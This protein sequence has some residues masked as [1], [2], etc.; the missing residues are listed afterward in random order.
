[1]DDLPAAP[2]AKSKSHKIV[3]WVLM[4]GLLV[5][6]IP[7]LGFMGYCTDRGWLDPAYQIGTYFLTACLIWLERDRLAEFHI[8]TLALIVIIFFKPIQTAYLAVRGAVGHP[9]AF[10]GSGAIA[11]WIIAAGLLLALWLGR[12]RPA[13]VTG[14]SM[15]WFGIGL[16][17]GFLTAVISGWLMS[18]QME[19]TGPLGGSGIFSYLLPAAR[20]ILYQLGYA[21][22]S[23]EPLFR[24]FLWGY[25][26]KAGWRN[27]WILLFQAGLFMVGHIYYIAE[28]PVS[29]W[30]IVPL[31]ALV[32]GG[33][34]WRSKT[35]SSSLA[36]HAAL[37]A[38]GRT[39][40]F[41]ISS[42][43]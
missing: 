20:D 22:V 13:R 24:G 35:I 29:F 31:G 15:L 19:E 2:S 12:P 11:I 5:L 8:D 14:S 32:L 34:V 18:F 10:P 16:L 42:S 17:I 27:I 21:A 9:L 25:L 39:I 36:A 38:F 4:I 6:R 33:L 30:L 28:Y 3:A 41:I 1:M 40:G 23:E 26:R 43:T 37:N 7:F